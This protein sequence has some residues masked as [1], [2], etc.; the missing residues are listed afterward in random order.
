MEDEI[1]DAGA[2]GVGDGETLGRGD[3]EMR[4]HGDSEPSTQHSPD[5]RPLTPDPL[6]GLRA[7]L[8]QALARELAS[9]RR[10]LLAENA[11]RIVPELVAGSTA[12]ELEA[13][14]EIAR[15]AFEAARAATLAAVAATPV[16]A[17]N[18]VRQSPSVEGMSPLEK[19]A[20]GLK[21]D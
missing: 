3:T 8:E 1:R 13:S 12:E 2:A 21:R 16:P 6:E 9:H 14:V 19:I 18:P 17:G 15:S 7:E 20:Y 11:G 5:P 4:R 10:A